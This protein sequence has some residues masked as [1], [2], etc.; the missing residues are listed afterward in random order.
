MVLTRQVCSPQQGHKY[1][2]LI[3]YRCAV[4]TETCGLTRS[5][6]PVPTGGTS[7]PWNNSSVPCSSVGTRCSPIYLVSSIPAAA[8]CSPPRLWVL[9]WFRDSPLSQV[10]S[11]CQMNSRGFIGFNCL[12]C[13]RSKTAPVCLQSSVANWCGACSSIAVKLW[14]L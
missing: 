8:G 5:P 6:V 11:D 9:C 10:H 4:H 14:L 3:R 7:R 13:F 12:A 2:S 1:T